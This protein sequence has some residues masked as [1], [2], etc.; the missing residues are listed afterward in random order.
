LKGVIITGAGE[1]AFV[2]GA[3][4][5]QFTNLNSQEGA[6]LSKLGH[7]IFDKIERSPI[8]VIAAVNGFCLGG[9]NELAMSCHMRIASPNA[10]FGQPEVNLGLIPGYGGTQRLI[11]YIGKGRAMELLLT[12]GMI[13][14]EKALDYGLVTHVV[15]GAE[16]LDQAK[17]LIN[18]IA[19]KGPLAI[20]KTIEKLFFLKSG[21]LFS[22]AQKV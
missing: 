5:K 2:A 22:K 14:A 10:K 12:G 18:K 6:K 9:G 20:K 21:S 7:D 15:E 16:L 13:D 11:Q 19:K 17:K 8:P 4:I 1:K 3:D